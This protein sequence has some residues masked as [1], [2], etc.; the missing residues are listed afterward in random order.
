VKR[1]SFARRVCGSVK[2]FRLK[3]AV[4]KHAGLKKKFD[5]A[6]GEL[7]SHRDITAR[8]YSALSREYGLSHDEV[9]VLLQNIKSAFVPPGSQR[10]DVNYENR[11][12]KEILARFGENKYVVVGKLCNIVFRR[13]MYEQSASRRVSRLRRQVEAQERKIA[14]IKGRKK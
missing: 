3:R 8:D 10:F 1:K 6:L 13:S 7:S 5:A 9:D 12:A 11:E 14:G 4:R 2:A